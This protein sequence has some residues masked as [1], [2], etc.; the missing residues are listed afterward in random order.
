[1]LFIKKQII[2]PQLFFDAIEGLE[3]YDDL[4][5]ENREIIT[6]LLLLEQ[7]GLCA[8][9]ERSIKRFSPTLEHFLPQSIFLALQ[10]SYY[11]LYVAWRAIR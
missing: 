2:P 5:V 10:L 9:C 3:K 1:M 4:Q 6:K 7:G 11:N 8:I